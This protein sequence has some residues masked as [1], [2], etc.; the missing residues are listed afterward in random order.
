MLFD[1]GFWLTPGMAA[2]RQLTSGFLHPAL[3]D[4]FDLPWGPNRERALKA[5]A[6]TSRLILPRSAP[7]PRPTMVPHAARSQ[8]ALGSLSTW[9]R[10]RV[11]ASLP[12]HRHLLEFT[13]NG[14]PLPPWER[15]G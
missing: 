10:A 4:Q 6:A 9:E 15:G 12:S 14:V 8:G 3:R 2:M 11:R 5:L 1:G 7:T 13:A